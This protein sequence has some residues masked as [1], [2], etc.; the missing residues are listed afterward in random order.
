MCF[1]QS[2]KDIHNKVP[3]NNGSGQVL[4]F[5]TCHREQQPPTCSN[6]ADISQQL[7]YNKLKQKD[8]EKGQKSQCNK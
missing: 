8:L 5:N 6:Q 7:A 3:T 1:N 4:G 2:F